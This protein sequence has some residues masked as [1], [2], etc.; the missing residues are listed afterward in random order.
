MIFLANDE[1]TQTVLERNIQIQAGS[2]RAIN[3]FI[4]R[5]LWFDLRIFDAPSSEKRGCQS[6][7]GIREPIN[8][9]P[10]TERHRGWC[11][12]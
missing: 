8:A 9:A 1:I 12:I 11:I 5:V 2:S 3:K 4:R 10:A 7:G 6:Q